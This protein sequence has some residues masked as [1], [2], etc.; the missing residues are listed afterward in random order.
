MDEVADI[1]GNGPPLVEFTI[2]LWSLD[3]DTSEE[4]IGWRWSQPQEVQAADLFRFV[5]EVLDRHIGRMER[6]QPRP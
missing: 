3:H 5:R 1:E 2:N 6:Q 4:Q